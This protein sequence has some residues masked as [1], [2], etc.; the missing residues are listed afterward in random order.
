MPNYPVVAVGT[1]T[2]KRKLRGVVTEGV[3]IGT[4]K[5]KLKLGPQAEIRPSTAM[6]QVVNK[7]IDRNSETKLKIDAPYNYNS[8]SDLQDWTQ[9]STAITGTGEVYSLVPKVT[10]GVRDY[11]RIG[12]TIQPTSL[13]VKVNVALGALAS[14][15]VYVDLWFCTAKGIKDPKLTAQIPV[16]TFMND[17]NGTNVPY[18]G[19]SYTAML[20]VN[21]T[22]FTVL[23]HKRI[24]LKKPYGDPQGLYS[25]A[26]A[27]PS[28]VYSLAQNTKSFSVKI[29]LPKKLTYLQAGDYTATNSFPFMMV[30]FYAADQF[31]GT[32]L[33]PTLPVYI[34]A[35]SHLYYKD[36]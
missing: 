4:T 5:R 30:G 24:L 10:E 35:Q 23:K 34:Q 8:G 6:T 36:E 9:F 27:P 29:D 1:T 28:S 15:N 33:T 13:T 12:N 25:G 14:S 31:G 21:S 18:D 2:K 26:G 19:T 17:G 7:I 11:E 22:Q 16:A 32:A 3:V 20:P